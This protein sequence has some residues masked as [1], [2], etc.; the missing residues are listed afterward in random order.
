MGYFSNGSE[1]M[2]YEDKFCS[3]CLNRQED[4][5]CP[6]IDLHFQWNYESCSEPVKRE[7]LNHFIPQDGIWNA[8]CRMF[9]EKL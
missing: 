3:R 6:I 2:D 4:G 8:Q 1:G 9:K 5:G 7:A